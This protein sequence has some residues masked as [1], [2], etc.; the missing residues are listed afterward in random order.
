MA[1]R[2]TF[3]VL[4]WD[5]PDK[6][7]DGSWV[8]LECSCGHSADIP[9]AGNWAG[10]IIATIGLLFVFDPPNLKPPS[11]FAPDVIQCRKCKKIYGPNEETH[12]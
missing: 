12:A 8:T 11:W 10:S 6:A 2:A 9:T 5:R 3:K 1:K 4:Q 7:R